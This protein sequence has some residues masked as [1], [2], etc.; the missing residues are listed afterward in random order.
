M[1]VISSSYLLTIILGGFFILPGVFNTDF[2]FPLV[3]EL[4]LKITAT[5]AICIVLIL[6]ILIPALSFFKKPR[7]P[8]ISPLLLSTMTLSVGVVTIFLSGLYVKLRTCSI[9]DTAWHCN[10]EGNSYVGLLVLVFFLASLVGLLAWATK[11]AKRLKH[12]N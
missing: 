9:D 10:V 7:A 3:V 8:K 2:H 12:K 1:F 11:M 5:L 6:A 4:F